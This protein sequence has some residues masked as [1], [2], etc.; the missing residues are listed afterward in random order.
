MD[1]PPPPRPTDTLALFRQRLR[2][3][4]SATRC[5]EAWCAE[6]GIGAGPIRSLRRP[7][8]PG[9]PDLRARLAALGGEAPR[10]RSVTLMRGDVALSDCDIWWLGSRLDPAMRAELDTTDR[11]F[12]LVVAPLRPVRQVVAESLPPPGGEHGLEQ[13]ALLLARGR[14]IAVVRERYRAA[15][16]AG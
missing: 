3:A 8:A 12:G 7:S 10:H 5:L 2:A 1:M 6:R 13:E 9:A 11:P 4:D 14:P 16:L 15:L